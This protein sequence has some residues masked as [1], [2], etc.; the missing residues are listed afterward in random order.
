MYKFRS[1]ICILAVSVSR[2]PVSCSVICGSHLVIGTSFGQIKILDSNTFSEISLYSVHPTDIA[3]ASES[4]PG[5]APV[6]RPV[7]ASKRPASAGPTRPK[8]SGTLSKEAAAAGGS[9][10]NTPSYMSKKG[11]P[12]APPK[13]W[14]GP[15]SGFISDKI[16]QP[17]APPSGVKASTD[18][19]GI[20]PDYD[21]LRVALLFLLLSA[22]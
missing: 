14:D 13:A 21:P 16:Y 10:S 18:V 3:A 12:K 17:P 9:S 1:C 19:L 22:P 4:R 2:G 8:S 15:S 11:R 7:T 6:S 20:I 5:T